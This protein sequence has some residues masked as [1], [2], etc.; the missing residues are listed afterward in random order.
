[1]L[2]KIGNEYL[3]EQAPIIRAESNVGN[4]DLL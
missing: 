2:V 4:I 1:M 3:E